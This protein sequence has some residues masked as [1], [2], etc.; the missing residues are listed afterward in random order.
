MGYKY[1]PKPRPTQAPDFVTRVKR[2]M[3][4][5]F[6]TSAEVIVTTT[7]EVRTPALFDRDLEVIKGLEGQYKNLQIISSRKGIILR[8]SFSEES[9]VDFNE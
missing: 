8:F 1:I 7:V 6:R 3:R 2:A 9:F 5:H 4:K